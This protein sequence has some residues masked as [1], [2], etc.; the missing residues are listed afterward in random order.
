MRKRSLL[1][2]AGLVALSAPMFGAIIIDFGDGGNASGTINTN[3]GD[4][5]GTNI[6]LSQVKV[7]PD[8]ATFT[9]LPATGACGGW[10]RQRPAGRAVGRR[11]RGFRDRCRWW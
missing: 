2:L 1:V 9:I 6:G 10:R 3:G 5:I 4:V 7:S 8:G 11:P